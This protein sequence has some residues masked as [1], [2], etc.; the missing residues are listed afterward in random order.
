M[1]SVEEVCDEI[2]LINNGKSILQ[3]D[4]NYIKNK[5]RNNSFEI[6]CTNENLKLDGFDILD[7]NKNRFLVKIPEKS[8]SKELIK[9]ILKSFRNSF[10]QRKNTFNGRYIY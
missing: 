2:T 4:I 1:E 7:K 3:G 6:E 10:F 9:E 8:N 5:Y